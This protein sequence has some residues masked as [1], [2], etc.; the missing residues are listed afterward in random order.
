MDSAV[1][2]FGASPSDDHFPPKSSKH[3]TPTESKFKL[4][5]A[6]LDNRLQLRSLLQLKRFSNRKLEPESSEGEER[7]EKCGAAIVEDGRRSIEKEPETLWRMQL[8]KFSWTYQKS[9]IC[10]ALGAGT[11][12]RDVFHRVLR[13]KV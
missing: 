1:L 3:E 9:K 8:K 12:K 13:A 6:A 10:F 4:E 7:R 11:E 5:S 2:P